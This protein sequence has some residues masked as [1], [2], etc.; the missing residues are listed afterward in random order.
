MAPSWM[1]HTVWPYCEIRRSGSSASARGSATSDRLANT[2]L[3]TKTRRDITRATSALSRIVRRTVITRVYLGTAN[4]ES[5]RY[6]LPLEPFALA[7]LQIYSIVRLTVPPSNRAIL[8][9]DPGNAGSFLRDRPRDTQPSHLGKQR[10]SF[11]SQFRRRAAW[12]TNDPAGLLKC[13]QNQSAI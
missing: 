9:S 2:V 5:G 12:P 10:G 3:N 6:G 7:D 1:R 8:L 11:Q 13:F 4:S